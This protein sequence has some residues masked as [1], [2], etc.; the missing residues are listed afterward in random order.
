MSIDAARSV[1]SAWTENKDAYRDFLTDI[2]EIFVIVEIGVHFGYSLFSFA[3]DY[4]KALVFG[5]DN[6][7]Y[8]DS[9]GARMHL[10]THVPEFK[11]I[12][13]LEMTSMQAAARWQHPDHYLDIDVLHID[14]GH[15]YND[16]KADYDAWSKFVRPGGVIFFHDINS[17][18]A[19]VGKFFDEL[20]GRKDKVDVGPGLGV[21]FKDA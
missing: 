20:E 19:S 12:R 13:I 5:V 10:T 17:H 16:V 14:A 15:D 9:E 8:G 11:N 7:S 2:G 6:F 21:F 1:P 3:H 18:A 4:P